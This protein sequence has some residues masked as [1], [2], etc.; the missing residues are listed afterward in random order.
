MA[1]E[2]QVYRTRD[3]RWSWRLRNL[4]N[5]QIT[6]TPERSWVRKLTCLANISEALWSFNTVSKKRVARFYRQGGAKRE[7]RW[8]LLSAGGKKLCGPGESFPSRSNADRNYETV[9]KAFRKA[10]VRVIH[11]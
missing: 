9:R 6:A 5:K 2:I 11:S 3:R 8:K 7:W 4:K 10:K 1:S